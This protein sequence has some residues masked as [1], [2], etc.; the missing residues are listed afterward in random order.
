MSVGELEGARPLA[1]CPRVAHQRS[2]L[3]LQPAVAI[4]PT[5][6]YSRMGDPPETVDPAFAASVQAYADLLARSLS[7]VEPAALQALEFDFRCAWE[8]GGQLF[9]CGNGGS[10][11][12]ALHL[13]NDF[14]YGV[15]M[16]T[17]RPGMKAHALPA[18]AAITT[19]LSNDLSYEDVFAEQLR[20][21]AG[22][23]DVLLALSGSGNSANIIAAIS[24]ARNLG[25]RSHL[26][27]GFDGGAAANKADNTLHVA[28]SN[29]Q[30]AE[31]AQLVIGHAL[32]RSIA[33][34]ALA[35]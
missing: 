32:M 29:M 11:G 23:G 20:V 16:P 1:G 9:I 33:G 21:L 17:S 5:I 26:I 34:D 3:P 31:D 19:C 22:P 12:N 8:N 35:L 6:R 13:A 2:V 15:G 14:L 25:M 24:E 10:A 28:V 7:S 4:E 27:V 30:V 18:N